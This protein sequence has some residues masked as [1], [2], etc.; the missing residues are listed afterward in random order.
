MT[1]A[2][3]ADGEIIQKKI[4]EIINL[5]TYYFTAT[6]SLIVGPFLQNYDIRRQAFDHM[7]I[8][9]AKFRYCSTTQAVHEDH[10]SNFKV[11]IYICPLVRTCFQVVKQCTN[12]EWSKISTTGDVR[13]MF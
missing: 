3:H 2:D 8:K 9:H 6:T 7:E 11:K 13:V 1:N 10:S 12:E 5:W 4:D